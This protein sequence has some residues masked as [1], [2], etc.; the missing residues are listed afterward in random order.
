MELKNCIYKFINSNNEINYVGKEIHL[1]NRIVNHN[2]I[3][4]EC[5]NSTYAIE[6]IEF[7]KQT[8]EDIEIIEKYFISKYNPKYNENK[9]LTIEIEET[10]SKKWELYNE[11][12]FAKRRFIKSIED[13]EFNLD[14]IK[15]DINIIDF[16]LM[17]TMTI[18]IALIFIINSNHT[19]D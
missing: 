16:Y 13:I 5:Y 4:E 15:I 7:E 9:E 12:S 19:K 8:K 6:Y 17:F 11:D 1:D 10:K 14:N 18:I 2:H 3:P